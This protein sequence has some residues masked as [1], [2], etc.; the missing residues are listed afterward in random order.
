MIEILEDPTLKKLNFIR[1]GFFTRLGGVS[2]GI[3]ASLNCAHPSNDEPSNVRENR[4][5]AM[6]HLGHTLE[7]L[8]TV[9]SIHSNTAIIVDKP[10]QE[11][12]KPEA[13]AIVTKLPQIVL[14]S[15]SA[16]CPIILFADNHAKIIGLA[17]AGWRGA[18]S[19]II[20]ATIEKMLLLGGKCAHI[21][22]AISPCI[23]Q[24]SYEVSAEFQQQFLEDDSYNQHYFK[25]SHKQNRFLFDLLGY[26]KNR[27]AKLNLKSVSSEVAIDTYSNEEK[28]FS[29]RRAFHKGEEWF[30]G[31][32]SCISIQ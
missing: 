27:L 11:Q 23:A 31:H 5:R 18:R 3:H 29:C 22:A 15:D 21:A 32:L 9:R 28:F 14:G 19:G 10:W 20:E 1:H 4:Q 7:S 8:V 6:L 12:N 16:D 24:N 30:G 26:V 25:N 2:T 13:D 17:H